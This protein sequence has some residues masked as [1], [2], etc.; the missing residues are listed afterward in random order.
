MLCLVHLLGGRIFKFLY[1]KKFT[2][3]N[4]NSGVKLKRRD[5]VTILP[6][7]CPEIEVQKT[8]SGNLLEK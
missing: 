6:F 2:F 5:G 7:H 1:F 4:K 8:S 3:A